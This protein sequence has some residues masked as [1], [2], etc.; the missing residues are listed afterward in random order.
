MESVVF[1]FVSTVLEEKPGRKHRTDNTACSPYTARQERRERATAHTR[2]EG[3]EET[4]PHIHSP[5]FESQVLSFPF[6]SL[7]ARP[8]GLSKKRDII[9]EKRE[10]K[11]ANS[12]LTAGSRL[13]HP[14]SASASSSSLTSPPH[15]RSHRFRR[16]GRRPISTDDES[17]IQTRER[18]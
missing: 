3:E 1:L 12:S 7:G 5:L 9:V 13:R 4:L 16:R 2:W 17:V 15:R 6:P 11:N 10:K 8:I 14:A 18:D